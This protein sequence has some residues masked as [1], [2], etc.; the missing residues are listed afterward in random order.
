MSRSLV[1][2]GLACRT[3]ATPPTITK[4][5]S[6][7]VRRRS[8][9]PSLNVGWSRRDSDTPA[10]PSACSSERLCRR[11]HLFQSAQPLRG[12]KFELLAHEALI[13]TSRSRRSLELQAM[14]GSPERSGK[15]LER[16]ICA[17]ALQ[18]RN[19]CLGNAETERELS[20]R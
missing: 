10:A 8:R 16:R 12:R 20:L 17:R 4:S 2:R 13:H 5:T 3:T 6:A 11:M 14:A 18:L 19:R 9:L 15:G 1:K 7:F